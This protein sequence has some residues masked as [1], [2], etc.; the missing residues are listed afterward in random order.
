MTDAKDIFTNL[1]TKTDQQ[2]KNDVKKD[3]KT[4]KK[5]NNTKQKRKCKESSSSGEI[6]IPDLDSSDDCSDSR[7]MG[8]RKRARLLTND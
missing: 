7:D 3:I 4:K 8:L 5:V 1:L 6:S 2:K